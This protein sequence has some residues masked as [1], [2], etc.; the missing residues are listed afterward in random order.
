MWVRSSREA[1]TED[2][3]SGP[4]PDVPLDQDLHKRL[5]MGHPNLLEHHLKGLK[6][7]SPEIDILASSE[8]IGC[9]LTV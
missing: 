8:T 1:L 6:A 4:P 2:L 7:L 3:E 9:T 5:F